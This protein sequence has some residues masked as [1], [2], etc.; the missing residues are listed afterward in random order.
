MSPATITNQAHQ[1]A[2][3]HNCRLVANCLVIITA[4]IT[5]MMM[6]TDPEP[7]HTSIL[8]GQMWVEELLHVHPDCIYCKLGVWKEVFL[9]LI[10]TLHSF[11]ITGSKYVTLEEQ[12]SMF[13][14]MCVTG[15]TI[16]HTGE[17]FQCS[18]DTI[19]KSFQKMLIIF[20][21]ALFY[22]TYVTLPNADTP[23]SQRIHHNTKMWPFFKNALGAIDGSHIPCAPSTIKCGWYWNWKGAMSQNC[24][25]ICSFDLQ[26]LFGYTGWEG[27]VTDGQ[28]WEAAL[29]C[30]LEIPDGYYY[31]ADAGYSGDDPWLLIPYHGVWYH[32]AEWSQASQRWAIDQ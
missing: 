26:F 17:R 12:L 28:V 7:Y 31:L 1:H 4:M 27:S 10:R 16:R 20:S 21:S 19:S 3:W 14:Y 15:L 24:P 25:F 2:A 8:S 30:R 5:L 23:P 9:E 6:P 32:L 11:G 13:L 22:T 29:D 18:N